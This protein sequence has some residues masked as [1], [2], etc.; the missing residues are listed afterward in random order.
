MSNVE[1]EREPQG[2]FLTQKYGPLPAWGWAAGAAVLAYLFL[3]YQAKKKKAVS[4]TGTPGT[5]TGTNALSSN[6]V[7]VSQPTPVLDGTYQVTVAPENSPNPIYSSTANGSTQGVGGSGP[8]AGTMQAGS[9]TDTSTQN[10]QPQ[11]QSS[12]PQ[13]QGSPTT[14]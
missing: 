7:G 8:A 3:Q 10:V 13:T 1:P 4:A 12:S 6:L 11:T 9:A 5:S 14:G 2:N